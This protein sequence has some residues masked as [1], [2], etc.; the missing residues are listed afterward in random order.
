[1]ITDQELKEARILANRL[2]DQAEQEKTDLRIFAIACL[3]V[4]AACY[5]YNGNGPFLSQDADYLAL[6]T[7]EIQEL[8]ERNV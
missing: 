8:K 7:L 3:Y 2:R 4:S 5:V 6:K 1:M